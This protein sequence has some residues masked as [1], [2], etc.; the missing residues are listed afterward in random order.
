MFTISGLW[1]TND[2]CLLISLL[3]QEES[4]AKTIG[5]NILKSIHYERHPWSVDLLPNK[6]RW[7]VGSGRL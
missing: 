5:K 7:T 4:Y 1:A 3:N 2:M 6:N